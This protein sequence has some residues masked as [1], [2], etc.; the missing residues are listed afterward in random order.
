MAPDPTTGT[1]Q[2]SAAFD[3]GLR[4][5]RPGQDRRDPEIDEL[6][7]LQRAAGK[8]VDDDA[9]DAPWRHNYPHA[10]KMSRRAYE[11]EKRHQIE[12]LKLQAWVKETGQ[13]IVIVFEG[14]DAAG[15]GGSIAFHRTH[16]P[17]GA[18]RRPGEADRA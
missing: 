3:E 4:D 10:K 6:A 18:R 16:E 17:R 1:T 11:R 13:K 9:P 12:L 7:E 14:R 8:K 15:K 2:H 5:G